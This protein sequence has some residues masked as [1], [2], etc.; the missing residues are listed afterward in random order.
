RFVVAWAHY[1]N[2]PYDTYAQV[3][4][5][6][7]TKSG[8]EFLVNTTTQGNQNAPSITALADGRFAVAWTDDTGDVSG[9]AVMAQIFDP[10]DHGVTITGTA[11]SDDLVG[12]PY[13]D[14]ISG[15][16]QGDQLWGGAGNDTLKGGGG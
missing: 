13:D 6:D 10:R 9:S 11:L 2:G 7:G 15:G 3:F 4:N 1:A 12:T 8:A 14:T 16:A 5:A